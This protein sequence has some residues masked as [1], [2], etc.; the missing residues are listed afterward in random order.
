MNNKTQTTTNQPNEAGFALIAM[1]GVL[2]I[3]VIMATVMLPNMVTSFN[4]QANETEKAILEDIGNSSATYLRSSR[5]WASTLA[6]HSPGYAAI[7]STQLLQNDRLFPRYYVL[8]PNM[9]SFS[10]G[11]GLTQTALAD[12]RILLISNRGADAAPSI[13]TGNDFNTW[14][15]TDESATPD[16]HIYRGNLASL[17]LKVTI[18]ALADGGSYQIDGTTTSSGG[19]TLSDYIRYHLPGTVVS[20]DEE[21]PYGTPEIQFVLTGNVAYQFDPLCESGSQWRVM[22]ASSCFA[23]IV[24]W[25]STQ[26]NAND[27]PGLSSWTDTEIVSFDKPNLT[28]EPGP[29]GQTS[30]TFA[31]I[32]DMAPFGPSDIDAGHYVNA[33]MTIAGLTLNQG[34]L[35]LSTT[36]NETLTSINSL[37]VNDEDVFIFRPV[38]LDDY[39]SGTF[40]MFMDASD[41]GISDDIEAVTLVEMNTTV[42]GQN[43]IQGDVLLYH[44]SVDIHRFTPT[45]LGS[46]TAGSL[47]L[48]IEG[49]DIDID[50]EFEGIE[51]IEEQTDLG[52]ITLQAGQI[53]ASFEGGVE[54]IG[55][56]EI[57]VD[58]TDITILNLTSVGS[59]TAGTATIMF[60][61]ADVALTT[62]NEGTDS[63]MIKGSPS[64]IVA[65]SITNSD[66]ET[67]DITGWSLTGDLIGSPPAANQWGATTSSLMMSGPHGGTYYGN[68]QVEGA[69]GSGLHR[70]GIYQRVDVSAYTAE[71]DVGTATVTINGYGHG[72][73]A[74]DYSFLRIAFYDAVSGGNQLGTD[75][76]SNSA[77]QTDTWT[78]LNIGSQSV[79]AGTRSI[80]LFA[81]AT[82]GVT[83]GTYENAGV[84]DISGYLL[85]P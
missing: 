20:L 65:L 72:E 14:W 32:V 47:S 62:T 33:A 85:L 3:V 22:P 2:A 81:I 51:L 55:D 17:F 54:E 23:P 30:G 36:D 42:A 70:H 28:F 27:A 41:I 6:V 31:L 73:D 40:F 67:G 58:V 43:L 79:P 53:L 4:N 52:D 29:T 63:I 68:A 60:D 83:G 38:S 44:N 24:L 8:H 74:Q 64:T 35:L 61:G 76:D 71:I 59:D 46:T 11:T 10:N 34:D 45:S 18:K 49:N 66:F 21:D 37:S 19:G 9:S 57:D 13:S 50:S 1:M 56:N 77:T 84:D 69:V 82:K 80:E 75:V 78:F 15:N 39:S 12:A 16:L 5:N 26:G 25:L 7:D 48:F